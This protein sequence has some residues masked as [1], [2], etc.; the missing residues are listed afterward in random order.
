VIIENNEEQEGTPKSNFK[1][2]FG[3]GNSPGIIFRKRKDLN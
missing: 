1:F 2:G 3:E